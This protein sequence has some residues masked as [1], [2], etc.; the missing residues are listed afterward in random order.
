[1]LAFILYD[2]PT[3][4]N[5]TDRTRFI[6]HPA[7]SSRELARLSSVPTPVPPRSSASPANHPAPRRT[8][9]LRLPAFFGPAGHIASMPSMPRHV[10]T[11]QLFFTMMD[12]DSTRRARQCAQRPAQRTAHSQRMRAVNV[13]K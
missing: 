6:L 3:K 2:Q 4:H 1:M 8:A 9:Q 11:P 7:R 13:K 12:D 10:L 5:H